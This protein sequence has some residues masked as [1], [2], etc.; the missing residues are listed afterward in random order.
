MHSS[1]TSPEFQIIF[2]LLNMIIIFF[3]FTSHNIW[4][5]F[6]ILQTL[7]E[8]IS[9][10]YYSYRNSSSC[11]VDCSWFYSFSLHTQMFQNLILLSWTFCNYF[12]WRSLILWFHILF[13][14]V[15][16]TSFPQPFKK[17]PQSEKH[18]EL[19]VYFIFGTPSYSKSRKIFAQWCYHTNPSKLRNLA[20]FETQAQRFYSPYDKDNNIHWISLRQINLRVR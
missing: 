13:K 14:F 10:A 18:K 4:S 19:C 17:M 6:Y 9:M 20:Q 8:S 12:C 11:K 7:V 1:I 3:N 2:F 15:S 5:P 16:N